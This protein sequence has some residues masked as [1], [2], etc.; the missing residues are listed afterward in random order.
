[1]RFEGQSLAGSGKKESRCAGYAA[2]EDDDIR[3][4]SRGVLI[5]YQAEV[6]TEVLKSL[7]RAAVGGVRVTG[8]VRVWTSFRARGR[9]WVRTKTRTGHRNFRTG[10]VALGC[11]GDSGD[12]FFET[13]ESG[14]LIA[15]VACGDKI[16]YFGA[17][18]GKVPEFAARRNSFKVSWA[19]VGDAVVD[20][21]G[22]AD[23]G[24]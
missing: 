16:F 22:G 4:E 12:F 23:P 18:I 5:Q 24:A 17:V 14:E 8:I 7:A 9:T 11:V 1:M 13:R 15:Q 21:K 20:H 10:M 2:A 3:P 6:I 19:A